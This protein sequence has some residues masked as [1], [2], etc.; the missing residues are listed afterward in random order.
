MLS[1]AGQ[2]STFYYY[3]DQSGNIVENE[4]TN[5]VTQQNTTPDKITNVTALTAGANTPIA[6][7]SYKQQQ[8]VVVSLYN[9][10][11]S[12]LTSL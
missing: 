6:A 7:I 5:G 11:H 9:P 10:P 12:C 4:F 2:S 8:N 1:P 3:I